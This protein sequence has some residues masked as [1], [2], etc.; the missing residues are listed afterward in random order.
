MRAHRPVAVQLA[1]GRPGSGRSG[2]RPAADRQRAPP[3]ETFDGRKHRVADAAALA[4]A[5]GAQPVQVRVDTDHQSEPVSPTWRGSTHACGWLR[6]FRAEP[7]GAITAAFDLDF[8]GQSLLRSGTYRYLSPALTVRKS[9]ETVVGMSS[10][11]L[12]NNPNMQLEAPEVH[13]QQTDT[14]SDEQTQT[15]TSAQAS[16]SGDGGVA[17]GGARRARAARGD[18]GG[19]PRGGGQAHPA[20]GFRSSPSDRARAEGGR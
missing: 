4:A 15:Q 19:A 20:R 12:L 1:A 17:R 9:D 16:T 5:I 6:D 2:G 7:N 11:A 3:L 13:N 8:V 14:K 18:G 10:L